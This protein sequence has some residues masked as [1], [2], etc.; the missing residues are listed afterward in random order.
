MQKFEEEKE[1]IRRL[2][3]ASDVMENRLNLVST[4]MPYF[5]IKLHG[6]DFDT[7]FIE[8]VL[9]LKIGIGLIN[10]GKDTAVNIE[11]FHIVLQLNHFLKTIIMKRI[12]P[13]LMCIFQ[14]ILPKLM[15]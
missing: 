15:M 9:R 11:L 1:N 4:L 8:G 14:R 10:I 3:R 12:S 7:G 5:D 6:D 2:E 13:L